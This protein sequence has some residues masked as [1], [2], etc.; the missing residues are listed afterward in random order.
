[1][2]RRRLVDDV[3]GQ[4]AGRTSRESG[5][6]HH[7]LDRANPAGQ[8]ASA[9]A[10]ECG[11]AV[12]GPDVVN[13]LHYH[14]VG[15][16]A[17]ECINPNAPYGAPICLY[18]AGLGYT[19]QQ[20]QEYV[21]TWPRFR[22]TPKGKTWHVER[23]GHLVASGTGLQACA[24]WDPAKTVD[25]VRVLCDRI[26]ATASRC[27][28][29]VFPPARVTLQP[30]ARERVSIA[31]GLVEGDVP[32]TVY[33]EGDW[34][35]IAFGRKPSD[36]LRG[37]L[38]QAG[39]RWGQRRGAWCFKRTGVDLAALGLA[40][41]S[42]SPADEPAPPPA[43]APIATAPWM[44]TRRAYQESKALRVA[45]GVPILNVQDG[46][47]HQAAIRQALAVGLPVPAFVLADYP[48]LA[49]LAPTELAQ[50]DNGAEPAQQDDGAELAQQ[51]DGAESAQQDDGAAVAPAETPATGDE[52]TRASA[53]EPAPGADAYHRAEFDCPACGLTFE[54]LVGPEVS[55]SLAQCPH[56]GR[57]TDPARRLDMPATWR[58]HG[59]ALVALMPRLVDDEVLRARMGNAPDQ[60]RL[61]FDRRVDDLLPELVDT[62]WEFY[63]LLAEQPTVMAGL[64]DW[65]FR[66]YHPLAPADSTTAHRLAVGAEADRVLS[67]EEVAEAVALTR[68]SQPLD[69]ETVPVQ[70]ASGPGH[71]IQDPSPLRIAAQPR[72]T[73]TGQLAMF[74]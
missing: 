63:R 66:W 36:G 50:Q 42:A 68:G 35:W 31:A 9:Y 54:G 71:T 25:A 2:A 3:P 52:P 64:L 20:E 38:K 29:Q 24:H 55:R 7:A 23:D 41:R 67:G 44:M 69:A 57:A 8:H 62:H 72:L 6:N 60:A 39:A 37:R 4:P 45:G 16:V 48:D 58:G 47:D 26:E 59:A 43:A 21:R 51:D 11:A 13:P 22:A 61:A 74:G 65:L 34:T 33:K 56:C 1:M 10:R 32:F 27:A 46:R 49:A 12:V 73:S 17:E 18:C 53:V 14:G 5:G 40:A 19:R 28:R 30:T 70:P 15:A